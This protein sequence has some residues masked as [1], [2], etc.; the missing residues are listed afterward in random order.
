MQKNPPAHLKHT[1][2]TES[3]KDFERSFLPYLQYLFLL[4]YLNFTKEYN[5]PKEKISFHYKHIRVKPDKENSFCR[6]YNVI[7]NKGREVLLLITIHWISLLL[8]NRTLLRPQVY[9]KKFWSSTKF[10][11]SFS[12]FMG[13]YSNVTQL[14]KTIFRTNLKP[15]GKQRAIG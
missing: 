10:Q 8:I 5:I 1:F 4:I 7:W 2:C 3:Y 14:W 9:L 11:S 12:L 6:C 15:S 13:H